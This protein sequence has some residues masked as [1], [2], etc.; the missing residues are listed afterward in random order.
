MDRGDRQATVKRVT[1][2]DMTEVRL[3]SSSSTEVEKIRYEV[4]SDSKQNILLDWSSWA[5]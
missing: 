4:V 5:T 3:S 2:S 1:E